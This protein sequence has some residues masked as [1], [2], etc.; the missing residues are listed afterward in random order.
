MSRKPNFETLAIRTQTSRT[1]QRE[2][3]TPLYPTSSFVFDSA[4]DARAKFADEVEGNIYS[5]YSNPNTDEFVHKM[6]LLEGANDGIA[7][8]SGMA[9]IFAGLMSHLKTGDHVLICKSVFGTTYQVATNWLPQWNI[10]YTFIDVYHTE[11]WEKEVK[12]NT[13]MIL[14]ETPT[15]PGLDLIDLE[16]VQKFARAHNLISLVDNCFATPYIQK[17]F[18]YGAD[19]VCHSATKFIDGQGRVLGG[20]ILGKEE[21]IEPIRKFARQTGPA[22]SPFNSWILSKS[23]ETLAVRL[24]KHCAN[25]MILAKH[26]EKHANVQQVK[27]PFLPSHPQYDL[28][29]RQMKLGGGL[30]CF[31]VNGEIEGAKKFLDSLK[32]LSLSSNLGDT[33][34]IVTHPATTTHSKLSEEDRLSVGIKNGT[35]RVSV[36]LEHIDDIIVDIDNALKQ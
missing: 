7:T 4:E 22:I 17:P 33:R 10:E 12:A 15:N 13:K 1:E 23:L 16:W 21:M 35:I 9:A 14:L 6:C 27:Y 3:S 29:K 8:A 34:T 5:R 18:D 20:L 24:E 2:H 32:M 36:G 19:L 28:A 11:N 30:V 25:A 31:E 26:L